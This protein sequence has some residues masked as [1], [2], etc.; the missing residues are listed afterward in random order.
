MTWVKVDESARSHPKFFRA[1][2]LAWG[3]WNAGLGYCNQRLTNGFIPLGD[4]ELV[5]PG[6]LPPDRETAIE[7][8]VRERSLHVVTKGKRVECHS[9]GWCRRFP[10]RESGYLMH[11]YLDYQPSRKQVELLR[12]IRLHAAR[13]GG[14]KS[15]K[16]RN[17]VGST[18]P[19]P[20]R[21]TP[22]RT[23]PVRTE[24]AKDEKR[25][26]LALTDEAFL[27]AIRSN[28]AYQGIDIDTE[29]GKLD[30]WLLLPRNRGKQRTRQRIVNWLNRV[31]RPLRVAAPH[32]HVGLDLR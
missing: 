8:L 12:K 17:Q 19:Q 18:T 5:F 4:L 3:W 21:P 28:P 1:G 2:C 24:E 7:A 10:A 20:T 30:A 14:E 15:A 29:L 23:V 11:D 27:A 26:G 16:V 9:S 22:V 31:E 32:A 13:K 6:M 25:R